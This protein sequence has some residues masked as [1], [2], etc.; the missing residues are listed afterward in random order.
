MAMRWVL[1][2]PEDHS[3]KI[4]KSVLRLLVF[5][6]PVVVFG[7]FGMVYLADRG[8][9]VI[10]VN[11][12][13]GYD[14]LILAEAKNLFAQQGVQVKVER[15]DSTVDELRALQEGRLHAAGL[16]LDEAFSAIGSGVA[17][18]IALIIDYSTGGDMIVGKEEIA[19]VADLRGKRVGYEGTVVGE[20]L[21]RRALELHAMKNTDVHLINIPAKDWQIAFEEGRIEALVCFNPVAST[22]L[23]EAGGNLI[24]SSAD[25]PFEIIDVLVFSEDFFATRHTEVVGIVRGWFDALDFRDRHLQ[26]AAQI[27]A[28]D[29]HIQPEHYINGL[30]GLTAPDLLENRRMLDIRSKH[31]IFKYSQRIVDFMLSKG[32]LAQRINTMNV[33]D[34][35]IVEELAGP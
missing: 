21:L 34:P 32:L 9:V 11:T 14:P 28:N 23:N 13:T 4:P 25:I 18:K 17:V 35:S 26:D 3:M 12:W 22:L 8:P 24:F 33:F 31:N 1:S 7:Y 27:I 6:L 19:T 29:K 15:F 2:Q 20:Y 5:V 30:T 16:T 10:G